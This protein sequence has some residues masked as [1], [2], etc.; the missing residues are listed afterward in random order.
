VTRFKI[1]GPLLCVG[2]ATVV[3]CATL[4]PKG[5]RLAAALKFSHKKHADEGVE[6]GDCHGDVA[7]DKGPTD[8]RFIKGKQSCKECHEEQVDKQCGYCHL[9]QDKKITL[10]RLKRRLRFS[11]AAHAKRTKGCGD[12]HQAATTAAHPGVSL[13]PTMKGCVSRCHQKEMRAQRCDSCHVDLQ[14][15][16]LKPVA[17]LGHQA[18]FLK[19]HG[20][21]ARD[22]ARCASCHD[23]T[24]CAD[25]HAK[26]APMKISL[27][28]PERTKARFIHRGDWL[29]RHGVKA[30]AEPA[31]CR[32]CHGGRHCSSCHELQGVVPPTKATAGVGGARNPHG[33]AW[34]TPGAAGFHGR[35][36]RRNISSCAACHDQGASSNCVSCHTVGGLGGSP[37][38]RSFRWRNKESA[39][40]T[41]LVCAACHRGGAGCP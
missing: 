28:F 21:L 24:H 5:D 20:P 27:A 12:C 4:Q 11:H 37:H 32:K 31:T 34:M 33:P 1:F 15:Q 40:R 36:A 3:A 26:T 8:G 29:G 10:T 25:C 38:P 18:G 16:R 23:Q 41:A 19:R 30:S 7:K 6:C 9:G 17:Q 35:K 22:A 13:V 39:C 2:V 14:R